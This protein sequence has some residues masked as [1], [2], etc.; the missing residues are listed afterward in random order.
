METSLA[1]PSRIPHSSLSPATQGGRQYFGRGT[2][3]SRSLLYLGTTTHSLQ[4][5]RLGATCRSGSSPPRRTLHP[6][7]TIVARHDR[8]PLLM[9]DHSDSTRRTLATHT[10]TP[11][12]D[13]WTRSRR[14]QPPARY[15]PTGTHHVQFVPPPRWASPRRNTNAQV[16]EH[17]LKNFLS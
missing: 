12:Y 3:R 1:L 17:T 2:P 14:N 6:I 11:T 9:H 15:S 5:G 7:H 10:T 13:H 16:L 4:L 8:E